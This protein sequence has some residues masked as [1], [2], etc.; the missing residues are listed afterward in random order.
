MKNITLTLLYLSMFCTSLY[1]TNWT[2]VGDN[3]LGEGEADNLGTS[4]AISRDGTTVVVGVPGDDDGGISAGSVRVFQV[5][6]N[7]TQIGIDIHGFSNYE[8]FGKATA[9]S[10]NGNVI[11]VGLTN[12]VKVYQWDASLNFHTQKG[13]TITNGTID[14]QSLA[15]SDDGNSLL[16][17]RTNYGM[18]LYDFDGVNWINRGEAGLGKP[19]NTNNY[20]G[21]V[22]AMSED[23]TVIATGDPYS[24]GTVRVFEWVDDAWNEINVQVSPSSS[25]A[26]GTSVAL[27]SDGSRLALGSP[28]ANGPD[29]E[30]GKIEIF[31]RGD[32]GYTKVGQTIYGETSISEFG[33]RVAISSDGNIVTSVGQSTIRSYEWNGHF[34]TNKGNDIFYDVDD[35]TN[36]KDLEIHLSGD[37]NTIIVSQ[38]SNDSYMTNSGVASLYILT[39]STTPTNPVLDSDTFYESLEGSD[40]TVDVTP[41][42]DSSTSYSYQWYFKDFAIPAIYGGTSSSILITGSS[43]SNGTYKVEI[44]NETGTTTRQFEYR[45]FVDSDGDGLSDYRES[46][47]LNTDPNSLDSDG[48]SLSDGDEI[49]IHSTNPALSDTNGDGFDDGFIVIN[50]FDIQS[51]YTPLMSNAQQQIADLRTG[52]TI[53]N[54]NEGIANITMI[55]EETSD[56]NDWSSATTS[57]KTIQVDAPAGTRFYR[58]KMTE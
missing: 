12:E 55:L 29:G 45:L 4:I 25:D 57:E 34:W 11:A 54:V 35:A 15:L 47:L 38:P 56:L 52:S 39:P 50:G 46:N 42:D 48:D 16:V 36:H 18:T 51:D 13:N 2:L 14:P 23:A 40:I 41:A 19:A 10:A 21:S 53:I 5:K 8:S 44:S 58:F 31:H 43:T 26:L 30:R 33:R 1:A 9:I 37:G 6:N 7:L 17:G 22:V 28:D 27:N 20:S 24:R 3:I 32:T 49:N